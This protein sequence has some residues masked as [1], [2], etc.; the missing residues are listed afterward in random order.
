MSI[1]RWNND[2]L[3]SGIRLSEVINSFMSV[4]CA[5]RHQ[6]L[7]THKTPAGRLA[8]LKSA[9]LKLAGSHAEPVTQQRCRFVLSCERWELRCW[10]QIWQANLMTSHLRLGGR[11]GRNRHP[12][13]LPH[14]SGASGSASCTRH[15]TLVMRA[16]GR[17]CVQEVR[18][19]KRLWSE[20]TCEIVERG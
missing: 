6:L 10:Q 12:R 2:S 9:Q 3:P 13:P 8:C 20:N 1:I 16:I 5:S 7:Q 19:V 17:R 18:G 14:S 4:T 15:Q 11:G